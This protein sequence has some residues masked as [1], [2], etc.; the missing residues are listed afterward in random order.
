MSDHSVIAQAVVERGMLDSIAA[1][2]GNARYQ[3]EAWIGPG[4]AKWLI[5]AGMVLLVLWAF[6]RR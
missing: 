2:V 4:N 6:R 1:G 5:I 3:L